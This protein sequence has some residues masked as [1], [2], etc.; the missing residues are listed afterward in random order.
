MISSSSF[1]CYPGKYSWSFTGQTLRNH[2]MAKVS[3]AVCCH[4]CSWGADMNNLEKSSMEKSCLRSTGRRYGPRHEREESKQNETKWVAQMCPAVKTTYNS[5]NLTPDE[6]QHR[7]Y[8]N[9]AE[10]DSP[11]NISPDAAAGCWA[12]GAG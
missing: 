8:Y 2:G 10:H 6:R 1:H 5:V 3:S 9:S 4:L 12:T 11:A 7:V